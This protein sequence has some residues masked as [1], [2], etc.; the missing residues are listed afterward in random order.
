ML[1]E[2]KNDTASALLELGRIIVE[3]RKEVK[4]E[5]S[6]LTDAVTA[7]TMSHVETKKDRESD[8][9]RMDRFEENQK[10]QG[11]ELKDMNELIIVLDERAKNNKSRWDRI[12]SVVTAVSTVGIIGYLGLK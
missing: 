6:K 11:K 9:A 4:E 5:I 3:D 12:M 2:M 8:Y 10:E 1:D 7:L